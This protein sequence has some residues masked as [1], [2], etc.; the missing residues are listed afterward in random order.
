[1]SK[2]EQKGIKKLEKPLIETKNN[3]NNNSDSTTCVNNRIR[4]RKNHPRLDQPSLSLLEK[5]GLKKSLKSDINDSTSND[6]NIY[7]S[8]DNKEG[9]LNIESIGDVENTEYNSNNNKAKTKTDDDGSESN[10]SQNIGNNSNILCNKNAI[11]S[12]LNCKNK[13]NTKRAEFDDN[14]EDELLKPSPKLPMVKFDSEGDFFK[15]P[16]EGRHQI[17]TFIS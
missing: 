16:I 2:N 15:E 11:A 4:T 10:E 8:E 9:S 1:M 12:R 6:L 13:K 14:L 17:K 5:I 7:A 3:N